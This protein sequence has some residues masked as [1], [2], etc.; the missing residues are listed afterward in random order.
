MRMLKVKKKT[1]NT[2]ASKLSVVIG[3]LASVDGLACGL[4]VDLAQITD[5]CY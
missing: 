4:L 5:E 2:G 3:V 1:V